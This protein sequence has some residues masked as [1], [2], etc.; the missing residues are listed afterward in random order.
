M[1]RHHCGDGDALDLVEHVDPWDR[2][3]RAG[4]RQ[5]RLHDDITGEKHT[6]RGEIDGD[7]VRTVRPPSILQDH[8][9]P[10]AQVEP[11]LAIEHEVRRDHPQGRELRTWRKADGL[12]DDRVLSLHEDAAG[13]LWIGTWASGVDKMQDG[14]LTHY[15]QKDGLAH[16]MVRAF[17]ETPDDLVAGDGAVEK[18]LPHQ[19]I[20]RGILEQAAARNRG[21][22]DARAV[23]QF[24]PA[25]GA[26]GVRDV[27]S[28]GIERKPP[29]A[30]SGNRGVARAVG[31][32]DEQVLALLSRHW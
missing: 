12:S 7:I 28:L 16:D 21:P 32:L 22:L 24:P 3:R 25:V 9:A 20:G 26:F 6:L 1:S 27:D 2:P 19:R 18:C 31:N 13:A 4:V 5:R 30:Q 17:A 15:S 8:L 29:R 11:E 14:R 10:A 23:E